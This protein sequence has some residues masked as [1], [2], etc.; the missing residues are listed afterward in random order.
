[1][2][3]SNWPRAFQLWNAKECYKMD[4]DSKALNPIRDCIHFIPAQE[5]M[6]VNYNKRFWL[7][8][9]EE[10]VETANDIG[11]TVNMDLVAGKLEST[12]IRLMN[13][14]STTRLTTSEDHL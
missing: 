2:F 12:N 6:E 7:G 4:V 5:D 8:S 13:P 9:I 11:D 3:S 10:S 1:M 14:I